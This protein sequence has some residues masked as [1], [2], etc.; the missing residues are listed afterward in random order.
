VNASVADRCRASRA[1]VAT[2]AMMDDSILDTMVFEG[3]VLRAMATVMWGS[4]LGAASYLGRY[5]RQIH[6]TCDVLCCRYRYCTLKKI[7]LRVG[8]GT[9]EFSRILLTESVGPVHFS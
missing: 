6:I 9:A 7:S 4:G 8:W 1:A 2:T 5:G 3:E